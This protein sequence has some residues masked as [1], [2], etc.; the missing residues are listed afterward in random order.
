V[1]T[2]LQD[3]KS[4]TSSALPSGNIAAL[5][6]LSEWE[7]LAGWNAAILWATLDPTTALE[8]VPI[9]EKVI[10]EDVVYAPLTS[11]AT[12]KTAIQEN[13]SDQKTEQDKS[14]SDLVPISPAM[15]HA[16]VNGIC[17]VL[18][19]ANAVPFDTKNRLTQLLQRPDISIELRGELYRGLARFIPPTEIPSLA[20]SLEV[21]DSRT[22]PPKYLRRAAMDACI[23]HGLWFYAEPN[24]FSQRDHSQ[25]QS[26]EFESSVWP[27]DIMQVR[28]DSDSVMRWNFG[29]WVALVRHPDAEAILIAQ[30]KDADS[31]VQNKAIEHLGIL[32]TEKALEILQ[33]QTKRPQES[34]RIAAILGLTPWGAHYLA[35]LKDDSSA[36]VRRTVAE[37][38]SRTASP[39]AALILRSLIN[40]R[41]SAVQLTVI[42]S[43][44]QW[45][46][47]LAIPLLLEAIQEGAYKTRRKSVIA[48]IDRTGSGG[49]ISIEAPK[50]E[51]IAAVRELVR[52]E[53]LP[54]GFWDQLMQQGLQNTSE[55]NQSRLAEIQAYFQE[56]LNQSSTSTEYHHAYQE[57]ANISPTEIGVLEKLIL[58][59]SIEIPNE[60]YTELLP[61]LDSNY[62]ALNQL[63]SS[64]ISDRRKAAQQLLINSQNVSL[65]PTI[66][67]RLRKLMTHE[68]DRLVW[69]IV[70]SAIAKDNYD[71]TAQLALLAINHNWPDI[72][73]L[74]CEYFG[75]YGLPEYAVW[76]LPLLNDKNDSVRL[77]AIN[78]IGH[79][80][81][82]IA[83]AGAFNSSP[84]Q[85]PGPSLRALM[86]HSNQRIRF[87]TVAALSR[88]GDVEGMQEMVRL[89]TD[90]LNSTRLD[91]VREMGDSGQTRF[92][93]PLIKLAWTERNHVT[94]K[95]ILSSLEKLVP[96]SEQPANLNPQINHSEQAKIWMNWW[97]TQHSGPSS[98]LFTGR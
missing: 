8:T 2:G 58:E 69:R 6:Q 1:R 93:E 83:I 48:L 64:H 14:K 62:I 45:P 91:A 84:D 26:Q 94:L 44:S 75:T 40:D 7:S 15:K 95:E 33:E 63:T 21:S 19:Q 28:W 79:C 71:A 30:L 68:Q 27:T 16:A 92:V 50:A 47:E 49:S 89:S 43:I 65:S 85:S 46:D 72:R 66:V 12:R 10:F 74:G 13:L 41:S 3:S 25:N 80:H 53:Q 81:N 88:L 87:E 98:R 5:K 67:K 59:T 73:I 82:P 54:A 61:Q 9:L 24:Q 60:I 51:R 22:L 78:A 70:M 29:Y 39:E 37:G 36:S 90:K 55:V 11:D 34:A 17:M 23:I 38:L 97:Q 32:G 76:L 77:A 42:Q 56:V 35:P 86:T 20:R 96:N 57:L 52:T 31:L 4:I 18:S